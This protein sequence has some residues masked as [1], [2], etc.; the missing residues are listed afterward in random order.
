MIDVHKSKRVFKLFC[1][2]Q[3]VA[4]DAKPKICSLLHSQ[5]LI[6]GLKSTWEKDSHKE[7]VGF[8][9]AAEGPA[10]SF[11]IYICYIA[12]MKH[13]LVYIHMPADFNLRYDA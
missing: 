6:R 3:S 13:K 10:I 5:E 2:A 11:I 4:S 9:Y 7:P 1:C 8:S 12:Q